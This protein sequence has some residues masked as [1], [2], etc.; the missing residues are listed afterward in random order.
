M[1]Y[2]LPVLFV[3]G[4][5]VLSS[6]CDNAKQEKVPRE[7]GE[8]LHPAPVVEKV[9]EPAPAPQDEVVAWVNDE[10]ISARELSNEVARLRAPIRGVPPERRAQVL[11]RMID[12]RLIAQWSKDHLVVDAAVDAELHR[13]EAE[14][15]GGRDGLMR[16]LDERD[17]TIEEFRAQ[18][19]VDLS[20][21]EKLAES[22]PPEEASLMALY[23]EVTNRPP[24]RTLVRLSSVLIDPKAD[25]R[26]VD[27]QLASVDSA[28][29]FSRL[30][31]RQRSLGWVD[32]TAIG[33]SLARVVF[34]VEPPGRSSPVATPAGTEI[35]WVHERTDEATPHFREL[36]PLLI[37][38]AQEMQLSHARADLLRRLRESAEIRIADVAEGSASN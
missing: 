22:E 2:T 21:A 11:Q 29:S 3:L 25:P 33:E 1:A 16:H 30:P 6:G 4:F 10:E 28:A 32:R 37:K 12:E 24:K 7:T 9:V 17:L 19:R 14:V 5:A 31:G 26:V 23:R 13:L 34:A 20:A 8:S 18:V 35:Y 27:P 15:F 36:E 38:R